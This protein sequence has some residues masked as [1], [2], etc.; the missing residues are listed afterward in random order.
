MKILA[1]HRCPW[2]GYKRSWKKTVGEGK[3]KK[4]N[5]E[6]AKKNEGGRE[7]KGKESIG[8]DFGLCWKQDREKGGATRFNKLWKTTPST[9]AAALV[10]FSPILSDFF[11]L[12]IPFSFCLFLHRR[13]HRLNPSTLSQKKNSP[14]EDKAYS[15]FWRKMVRALGGKLK[16]REEKRVA[17]CGDWWNKRRCIPLILT[18]VEPKRLWLRANLPVLLGSS[19]DW[20]VR[21]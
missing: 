13:H 5:F 17:G 15:S 18:R 12:F 8:R 10:N 1:W 6:V 21:M 9:T 20:G 14:S 11:S 2:I 3:E 4:T 19:R 7:W 16:S